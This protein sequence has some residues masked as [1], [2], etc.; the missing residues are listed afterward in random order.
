M[1]HP[2]LAIDD[3]NLVLYDSHN[4]PT[5]ASNTNGRAQPGQALYAV[6]QID[7]NFVVYSGRTVLWTANTNSE[8]RVRLAWVTVGLSIRKRSGMT[9]E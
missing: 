7:N 4:H 9:T 5:W 1:L 3:A 8:F 6:L 2:H